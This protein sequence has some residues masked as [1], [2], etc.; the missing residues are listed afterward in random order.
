MSSAVVGCSKPRSDATSRPRPVTNAQ[1]SEAA[2]RAE[3]SKLESSLLAHINEVRARGASCPGSEQAATSLPPLRRS[4]T[5]A[6]AAQAYSAEIARTG[7][8]SHESLQG[9]RP[10]SRAARA[11][12]TGR[13]V[14]EDLA[15]GQP[16]P[17]EVVADWLASPAHCR[18][19]VSRERA[20]AGVGFTRGSEGKPIWVF[21]A[22]SPP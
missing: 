9:L 15:W 11:G 20:E 13:D 12:Y 6:R 7:L 21:L 8:F 14:V 4:E 1:S 5:L 10:G 3:T 16:E 17:A 2:Q 22:G 19:L 18:A